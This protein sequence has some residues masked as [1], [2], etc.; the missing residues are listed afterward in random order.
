M[1]TNSRQLHVYNLRAYNYTFT[2][3]HIKIISLHQLTSLPFSNLFSTRLQQASL[4]DTLALCYTHCRAHAGH[5]PVVLS[6]RFFREAEKKP[7]LLSTSVRYAAQHWVTTHHTH[8][9]HFL[10]PGCSRRLRASIRRHWTSP[11]LWV[12]ERCSPVRI[13]TRCKA[14]SVRACVN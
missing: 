8:H 3:L 12:A 11:D 2:S 7:N 10:F 1:L 9:T 5:L 14:L 4:T 6:P 13:I